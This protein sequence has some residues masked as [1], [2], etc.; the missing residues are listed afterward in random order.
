LKVEE[1]RGEGR[2]KEEEEGGRREEE[3]GGGRRRRKEGGGRREEEGGRREEGGGRRE[4][5][6][7]LIS[8]RLRVNFELCVHLWVVATTPTQQQREEKGTGKGGR[9]KGRKNRSKKGRGGRREKRKKGR[10]RRREELTG[11]RLRV[12][13]ELCVHHWVASTRRPTPAS[14]STTTSPQEEKNWWPVRRILLNFLI[15]K[16]RDSPKEIFFEISR[17]IRDDSLESGT[18][19]VFFWHVRVRYP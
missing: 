11:F 18:F 2:G 4:E 1:G 7:K 12:Y 14:S 8:F 13:L 9:K 3:E 17:E 6:G 19:G 5:G 10:G 16:P 15:R